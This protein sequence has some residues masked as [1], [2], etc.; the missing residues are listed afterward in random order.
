[1]QLLQESYLRR[2]LSVL[3]EEERDNRFIPTD[4]P[5]HGNVEDCLFSD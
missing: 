2:N 1:M 4:K 5:S 3:I